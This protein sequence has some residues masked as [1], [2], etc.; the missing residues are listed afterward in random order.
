MSKENKIKYIEEIANEYCLNLEH[1]GDLNSLSDIDLDILF[2]NCKY[3]K[4]YY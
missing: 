4:E 2:N 1:H 3:L